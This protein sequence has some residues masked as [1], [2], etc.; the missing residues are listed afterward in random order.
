MS[1]LTRQGE[2]MYRLENVS[3]HFPRAKSALGRIFD[4][5][6]STALDNISMSVKVGDSLGIVGE[7]GSGKT[8]LARLMIKLL[9]PTAGSVHF[10]GQPLGAMS[11]GQL[12][13]FRDQVQMVFQSTHTSLNP[14][15]TIATALV[16]SFRLEDGGA[17]LTK[18]LDMA[19]LPSSVL[20]KLPH[21]LSGGQR[22]RVGIAR[23]IARRPEVII[24]DEPT[25][26]LDV[27]L[28]GEVIEL[29]RELHREA[30]LTL[31]VI[32]HDLAMVAALCST[33]AV[34]HNGRIVERGSAPVVLHSPSDPYTQRLI[35]AIP[36]GIRRLAQ[37]PL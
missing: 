3:K 34:M 37:A 21:Q 18:L 36:R 9:E 14:R 20:D 11:K 12:G 24:A 29:L 7:S 32:S 28:Q 23:A 19:R 5:S 10:K 25:S 33:V 16:E 31:I 26:A 15:K 22:Q 2:E 8:T 1:E 4:R 35:D 27:S 13:S 6:H 30:R 17:S